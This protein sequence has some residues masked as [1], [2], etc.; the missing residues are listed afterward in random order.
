MT[1]GQAWPSSSAHLPF[2]FSEGLVSEVTCVFIFSI[3]YYNMAANQSGPSIG[4][5]INC[6]KTSKKCASHDYEHIPKNLEI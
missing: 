6:T 2:R 4:N 5:C 3:E 1:K